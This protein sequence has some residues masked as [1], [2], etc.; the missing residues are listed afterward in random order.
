MPRTKPR[1]QKKAAEVVVHQADSA[2]AK[3][4]PPPFPRPEVAAVQIQEEKKEEEKNADHSSAPVIQKRLK[5]RKNEIDEDEEIFGSV[6][7]ELETYKNYKTALLDLNDSD[8]TSM[9]TGT[10]HQVR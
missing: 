6:E 4:Q 2:V 10:D 5:K 8:L 1:N 3:E 7:E 9:P